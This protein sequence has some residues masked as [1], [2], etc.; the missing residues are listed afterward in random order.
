M[1]PQTS[2]ARER[3]ERSLTNALQA[4]HAE[5]AAQAA[6]ADAAM[7]ELLTEE[8]A[9]Q[10]KAQT[11]SKKSKKRKKASRAVA[12]SHEPREAPSADKMKVVARKVRWPKRWRDWNAE[13]T[14]P[15]PTLAPLLP[16]LFL[17][18]GPPTRGCAA[19]QELGLSTRFAV[20]KLKE[21][22]APSVHEELE[23]VYVRFM[24]DWATVPRSTLPIH[25]RIAIYKQATAPPPPPA[26]PANLSRPT[27]RHAAC[28]T[29][30]SRPRPPAAQFFEDLLKV[31]GKKA[32]R[33][34]LRA[35]APQLR[36][37]R[38]PQ[39]FDDRWLR[40]L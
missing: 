37:L 38:Q 6:R 40:S 33:R 8:A 26:P 32:S 27:P 25:V 1:S 24:E 29:P 9:E 23:S 4:T 36:S 7:E 17:S 5:Q 16:G 34:G 2:A 31:A 35:I 21:F 28:S 3:I 12:T 30:H 13:D 11:R 14:A 22:A 19:G 39:G 10:A 20:D 18:Q 15:P